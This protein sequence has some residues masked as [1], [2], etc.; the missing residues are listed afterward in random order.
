MKIAYFMFL[1][2]DIYFYYQIYIYFFRIEN[3]FKNK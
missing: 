3:Y 2:I 1:K